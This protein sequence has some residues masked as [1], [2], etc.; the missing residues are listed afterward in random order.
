MKH[1]F[2]IFISVGVT[3]YIYWTKVLRLHS[4]TSIVKLSNLSNLNFTFETT[5]QRIMYVIYRT[6]RLLHSNVNLRFEFSGAS[7]SYVMELP[8]RRAA[9]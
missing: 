6:T 4:F 9:G 2:N 5:L 8:V 1:G 3:S 7:T